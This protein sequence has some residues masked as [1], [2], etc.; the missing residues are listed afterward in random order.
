MITSERSDLSDAEWY[1]HQQD[2]IQYRIRKH[3]HKKN[4]P[5]NNKAIHRVLLE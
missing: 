5:F 1:I 3:L 4:T 2:V